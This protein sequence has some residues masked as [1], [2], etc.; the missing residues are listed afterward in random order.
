[1]NT[2]EL[3]A[4]LKRFKF[5]LLSKATDG[6]YKEAD[7]SS[8]RSVVIANSELN[9]LLPADITQQRSAAGFRRF[10]QAKGG[11]A[12]RR[13]FID[14]AFEPA[15]A[16]I[17]SLITNSDKFSLNED[18]YELGERLGR[19]GFGAVY[20]YHHKLLDM[21]FAIKVFEPAFASNDDKIE[22][23]KRFFR[24]A[25]ML[26]H[27]NHDN[28][29]R[30]YDIG[31][32]GGKP[33]IRLEFVDGRTLSK[34]IRDMGSVSFE[35][36]KK[37]IKG[38]LSGLLY[39]HENGIIHRDLKPSNIMVLKDG[40]IK[41][42]D[43]GVSTYLETGDHTRL[44]K[45]GEQICGG[46]Y[47]DPQLV[48]KPS[49][50]DPRS[51]IYSLGGLWFFLLTN[52]DPSADAQRVLQNLGS[53][54][55]TP[56]QIDII[57]RCLNSDADKRFQSCKEIMDL[58]FP[59][60]EANGVTAVMGKSSHRITDV[61][62]RDIFRHLNSGIREEYYENGYHGYYEFKLFGD[63]EELEF[64]KRL[65]QLDSMPSNDSRFPN[66]EADIRQHTINNEDWERNW[67]FTDD[68]LGLSTG[69]DDTL[70]RFLCEMFHPAVRDWKN[71]L[72]ERVC[73]EALRILNSLI[74]EDGYE[75]YESDKISGRP[76]FSYRY[77]L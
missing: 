34:C 21:D 18:S 8:D 44:T 14:E 4:L 48:S 3:E 10:I 45:T 5:G 35:R 9:K 16:Y 71:D 75:I 59:H 20:K 77:C 19:G 25:K 61:T 60:I 22:G 66:F 76:V 70:L 6:D 50:R 56:A 32:T 54:M 13:A 47:Q 28:I 73:L 46:A 67:I 57:L 17:D 30:V 41:I 62:R 63:F 37:P 27:L 7:F 68:R 2:R 40:T 42:I 74:T 64:L 24:E 29:V 38:I 26:F 31:R 49:L 52:R 15:L 33:F 23:E 58:L 11:Y 51:D 39:A 53:S 55:V 36:S 1:M 65:Y 72:E 43:F 12:E 69:D